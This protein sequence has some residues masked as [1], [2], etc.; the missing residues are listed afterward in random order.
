MTK[1]L[2]TFV[3]RLEKE[4]PGEILRISKPLS[5]LEHECVAILYQLEKQRKWPMVIFE[6]VTTGKGERWAGSV[7]FSNSGTWTKIGVAM[8]VPREKINSPPAVTEAIVKRSE[9]PIKYQVVS[10]DRAP[11]K[12]VVITGERVDLFDL[13]LYRKDEFDARPGWLCGV[14]IAKHPDTGRY[15]LSWH[16][17]HVHEP[18][19]SGVRIQLRHLW[20]YLMRYKELGYKEMPTAWVFGHHP[21]FDIAAAMQPGWEVDEYDFA[22]GLLGEPLR[23]TPSETL[24]EDFLVPADAEVVVEGYVHVTDREFNGPWTDYLRYYS[25][26]TLEPAF[27]PTAITMRKDPI[28]EHDFTG[29]SL[30]SD[31]WKAA[32]VWMVLK[33]RY[34]RVRAVNYVAPFTFIV[35]F[36]PDHP[37]EAKRLAT[38]AFGALGD[39]VKNIIIVDEDIDPFNLEEVFFAIATVVDPGT[40]QVQVFRELTAN[41]H[42]PAA[43]EYMRTG[44]LMIDATKP[45]DKP[46]PK[47]G[48]PPKRVMERIKLEDYVPREVLERLATGKILSWHAL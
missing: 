13:P 7:S 46:F 34:P 15:N 43:F 22:G 29:H 6:N 24:G 45:T 36:K 9:R 21:A 41:R 40:N 19:R 17:H 38:Y 39:T 44:G 25:P 35:Q 14:G 18:K 4:Y 5:L 3:E 37:G 27:R 20:D 47:I 12:E 48:H 32:S 23:V 42:D 26:Q 2:R 1:D 16:R 33:Q 30:L 28:F 31:I 11:V 8:D 10:R